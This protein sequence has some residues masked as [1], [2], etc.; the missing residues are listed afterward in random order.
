[1]EL[2]LDEFQGGELIYKFFLLLMF[3]MVD[4]SF[5]LLD[6]KFVDKDDIGG[7]VEGFIQFIDYFVEIILSNLVVFIFL[8]CYFFYVIK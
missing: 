8:W 3:L 7:D 1:M 4:S 2:F 6:N 5:Y